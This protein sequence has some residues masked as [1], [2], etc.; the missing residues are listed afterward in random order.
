M[1]ELRWLLAALARYVEE[2][3]R[4]QRVQTQLMLRSHWSASPEERAEFERIMQKARR[5]VGCA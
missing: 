2:L 5:E 1:G 4:M 3:T